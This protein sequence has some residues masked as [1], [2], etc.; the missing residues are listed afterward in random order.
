MNDFEDTL[1]AVRGIEGIKR[2]LEYGNDAPLTLV[3]DAARRTMQKLQHTKTKETTTN[4]S[5]KREI[6]YYE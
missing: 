4:Q 1:E 5:E 3:I 6:I 2:C